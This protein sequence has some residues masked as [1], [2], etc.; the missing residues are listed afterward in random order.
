MK[1][2]LI[3]LF[4]GSCTEALA[5]EKADNGNQCDVLADM[6]VAVQAL[7]LHDLDKEKVRAI[8]RDMYETLREP[9]YLV[10]LDAVIDESFRAKNAVTRPN[11]LGGYLSVQCNRNLGDLDI[12]LGNKVK[13]KPNVQKGL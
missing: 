13:P 6:G 1:F 9:K 11:D 12:F 2:L 3:L 10:W 5:L 8:T 4:V 7:R